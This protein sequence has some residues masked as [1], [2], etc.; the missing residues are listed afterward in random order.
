MD[1][2]KERI[3]PR[4]AWYD[5][6]S[7]ACKRMRL[8]VDYGTTV[9]SVGLI[10]L[11][12]VMR[13]PRLGLSVIAGIIA[14]MIA[15]EKIGA[16]GERWLHYRMAAEALEAEVQLHDHKAGPYAAGATDADRLLVERVE[17]ILKREAEG[18]IA[19]SRTHELSFERKLGN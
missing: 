3:T 19:L 9:L 8:V 7:V 5:S 17:S 1:Y 6:R 11:M 16:Y 12:E 13:F 10:V 18:W 15:I 14:I 2:I 4:I